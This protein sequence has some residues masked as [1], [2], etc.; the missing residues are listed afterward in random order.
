MEDTVRQRNSGE[1]NVKASKAAWFSPYL[2]YRGMERSMTRRA[3][4]YEG[5]IKSA[6][7]EIVSVIGE[8]WIEG[9][10]CGSVPS[11]ADTA[12]GV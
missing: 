9:L 7:N 8:Q 1:G 12:Y 11:R 3:L 4:T 6:T 2:T 10:M 5:Q